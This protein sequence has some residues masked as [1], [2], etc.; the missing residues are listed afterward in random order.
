MNW[1]RQLSSILSAA[2]DSVAKMRERL[3]VLGNAPKREAEYFPFTDK[4]YA[5]DFGTVTTTVPSLSPPQGLPSSSSSVQWADITSILSQL[6]TQKQAIES[7]TMKVGDVEREKQCQQ[8]HIQTLQ[9]EVSMLREDLS[10]KTRET[11]DRLGVDQGMEQWIRESGVDWSSWPR[12]TQLDV[13]KESLSSKV[14]REDLQQLQKEVEQ[15]KMRL[16]RQ[17]EANMLQVKE[18]RE[19]R[20]QYQHSCQM[21]QELTERCR[22][23]ST[24]LANTTSDCSHTQQEVRRIGA[25]VS[26]LEDEVRRLRERDAVMP[27]RTSPLPNPPATRSRFAVEEAARD[28]DLEDL[29]SIPS[30]ADISSEELSLLDDLSPHYK[31]TERQSSKSRVKIDFAGDVDD[32][33]QDFESDLSLTDL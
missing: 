23:H 4:S 29:S 16:R 13:P 8:R 10:Q 15:L 25:T 5:A 19:T 28:S 27:A 2:D 18:A 12:P 7:L 24:D 30:L 17:E 3:T 22:T 20:R 11:Y 32:G 31:P 1:D 6:Q 21:V 9:V 14:Q 33:D 26:E